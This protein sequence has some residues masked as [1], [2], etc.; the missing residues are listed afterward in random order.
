MLTLSRVQPAP[1]ILRFASSRNCCR[2]ESGSLAKAWVGYVLASAA[3]SFGKPQPGGGLASG[4]K[5]GLGGLSSEGRCRHGSSMEIPGR[6]EVV[7]HKT[8]PFGFAGGP[9]AHFLCARPV[10]RTLTACSFGKPQPGGGRRPGEGPGWVRVGHKRR[11]P[12]GSRSRVVTGVRAKARTGNVLPNGN[13]LPIPPFPIPRTIPPRR[14]IVVIHGFPPSSRPLSVFKARAQ[15]W[16]AER[17]AQEV[18]LPVSFTGSLLRFQG[19]FVGVSMG[20]YRTF[21]I[22][23]LLALGLALPIPGSYPPCPSE[24]VAP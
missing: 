16:T 17:V 4:R 15:C 10:P 7:S 20:T 11:V 22:L 19:R 18:S 8:R 5:P 14:P 6:V 3:S 24:V 9:R 21:V 2:M 12:Y 13:D 1:R 23:A